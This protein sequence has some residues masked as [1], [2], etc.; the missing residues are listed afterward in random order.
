MVTLGG[1]N[2]ATLLQYVHNYVGCFLRE[3]WGR[4]VFARVNRDIR[5]VSNRAYDRPLMEVARRV[6]DVRYAARQNDAATNL[7][8]RHIVQQVSHRGY[9][10]RHFRDVIP[11]K[12][13]VGKRRH[14]FRY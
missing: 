6:V 2:G 5:T 13:S 8:T 12:L 3:Q 14:N 11:Y 1:P 10:R 7:A 9:I 4:T